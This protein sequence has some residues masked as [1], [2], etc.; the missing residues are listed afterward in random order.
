MKICMVGLGIGKT[1]GAF[2]G[3]H[4]NNVINLSKKLAEEGHQVHIVT[5]PPIHSNST[6]HNSE[7]PRIHSDVFFHEIK[8]RGDYINANL[9]YS[10]SSIAK[11][12]LEIRKLHREER[13][14]IIHGHSGFSL[15]ALIP[16]IG[17][18]LSGVFSMHTLYCPL[19]KNV[20][21]REISKYCMRKLDL[22]TVL[23]ENTKE[24]LRNVVP[25]NKI[26][27]IP[28]LIDTSRYNSN[29][30]DSIAGTNSDET[31]MT[32]R[33]TREY[34]NNNA[35]SEQASMTLR[36]THEHENL[37]VTLAACLF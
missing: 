25:E 19:N 36:L 26:R 23:S 8:V 35:F 33:D 24:S 27:I 4:V 28:P 9:N 34:G 30:T 15:I 17:G 18:I 32:F 37:K 7:T 12:L 5:T 16:E 11:I 13:F 6:F 1:H 21:S 22:I 3:G 14:D 29:I 20:V 2:V 10:I 31:P